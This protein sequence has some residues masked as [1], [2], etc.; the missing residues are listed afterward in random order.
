M[1]LKLLFNFLINTN[2][3]GLNDSDRE[4]TGG[5]AIVRD[6]GIVFTGYSKEISLLC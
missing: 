5:G 2:T 1:N 3:T 4:G 6:S